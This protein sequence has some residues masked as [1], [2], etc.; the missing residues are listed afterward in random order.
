[1]GLCW[2]DVC[3]EKNCIFVNR[4]LQRKLNSS[5]SKAEYNKTSGNTWCISNPKY[6]SKRIVPLTKELRAILLREKE[7]QDFNKC[8]LG[9]HYKHYF[10]NRTNIPKAWNDIEKFTLYAKDEYE[11]GE[12]NENG[13]GIEMDFVNRAEDGRLTTDCALKHLCRVIHGK[14][15][16]EAISESFNIHSLRHTYASKLRAKGVPEHLVTSFLGHTSKGETQ[17]YLH[18]SEDEI[19][20]VYE[21]Q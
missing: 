18:V 16:E 19:I 6:N 13:E 8:I 1:M 20:N 14:E 5:V 12:I 11:Y 10:C 7:R 17:T 21:N 15:K 9:T 3:F 4:Q 2:S